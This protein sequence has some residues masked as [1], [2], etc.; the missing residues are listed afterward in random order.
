MTAAARFVVLP[1]LVIAA[2]AMALGWAGGKIDG[3]FVLHRGPPPSGQPVAAGL[4]Q[5][6]PALPVSPPAAP[7]IAATGLVI[8][9]ARVR[10]G[11][12]VDTFSQ[13]RDSGAR[14]HDAIDIAAPLGTPVL[15][16]AAGTVERLFVSRPGGNT[17][18]LRSPDRQLI[19]YY[20]HRDGYAPGLG[21]GQPVR[22]GLGIGRVGFSGNAD[23]AAPHLHFAVLQTTPEAKWYQP[24]LPLNPYPLLRAAPASAP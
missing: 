13:S 6:P 10:A 18:Y 3:L 24:A 15:A 19:Y 17:I 22:S 14:R 8:P 11:Q 21:E 23:P 1:L 9:V 7:A 2:A 16:A 5:A 12:L 20:A 4:P